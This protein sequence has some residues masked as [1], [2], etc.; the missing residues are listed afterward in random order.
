MK[1]LDLIRIKGLRMI[2]KIVVL[3]FNVNCGCYSDKEELAEQKARLD[4]FKKWAV[5]NNQLQN[6]QH[7]FCDN[8]F[9]Q[10]LQFIAAD[11]SKFFYN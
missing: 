2:E 6:V 7:F 9:G 1:D 5:E 10:Q 8:N 11:L 4:G 3:Q